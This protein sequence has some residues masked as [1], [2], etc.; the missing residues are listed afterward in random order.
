MGEDIC[1]QTNHPTQIT[2]EVYHA[3]ARVYHVM[4]IFWQGIHIFSP[5]GHIREILFLYGENLSIVSPVVT[6]ELLYKW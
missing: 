6:K 5:I 2:P 1:G 3:T 4:A